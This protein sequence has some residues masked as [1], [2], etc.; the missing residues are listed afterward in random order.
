MVLTRKHCIPCRGGIPP[1]TPKE[2]KPFLKQL[3]LD[4]QVINDKKISHLFA[5]KNFQ[6]A[7]DFVNMVAK[8]AEAEGH[9]PNIHLTGWNKVT[10]VLFT[11]KI[12]GLHENDFIVAAKIDKLVNDHP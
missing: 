9:H 7:I 10:I 12:Q 2:I 8:I 1:L 5:F 11:H 3:K 6:Q 4:W